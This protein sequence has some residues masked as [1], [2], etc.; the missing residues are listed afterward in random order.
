MEALET[1]Q[2]VDVL[3]PRDFEGMAERAVSV[4]GVSGRLEE[5]RCEKLGFE[6]VRDRS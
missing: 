6:Q 3:K 4:I 1:Y 5:D 2:P